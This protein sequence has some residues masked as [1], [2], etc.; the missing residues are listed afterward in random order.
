MLKRQ[1]LPYIA[2]FSTADSFN[3]KLSSNPGFV[4]SRHAPL[5]KIKVASFSLEL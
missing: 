3:P 5:S 1:T 2:H 4:A